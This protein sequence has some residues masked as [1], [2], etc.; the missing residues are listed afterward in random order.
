MANSSRSVEASFTKGTINYPFPPPCPPFSLSLSQDPS[1]Q[2]TPATTRATLFSQ[3]QSSSKS[4]LHSL[5]LILH[6]L[7]PLSCPTC[8]LSAQHFLKLLSPSEQKVLVFKSSTYL[9][10]FWSLLTQ[11]L[12]NFCHGLGDPWP[13]HWLL[14][15]L[16]FPPFLPP[17][18]SLLPSSLCCLIFIY[19]RM[20]MFLINQFLAIL[21][22][23]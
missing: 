12:S 6:F 22:S 10:F 15:Q 11:S 21:N 17:F 13:T 4:G 1:F 9:Y 18:R 2:R 7:V 8:C 16:T 20:P 5:H 3:F 14:W 19:F 23:H